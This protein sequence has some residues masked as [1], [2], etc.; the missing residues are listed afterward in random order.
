MADPTKELNI[1]PAPE[2]PQIRL[3]YRFGSENPKDPTEYQI[4]DN[5]VDYFPLRKPVSPPPL[6]AGFFEGL[7]KI[8]EA[9][10]E[11]DRAHIAYLDALIAYQKSFYDALIAWGQYRIAKA[12]TEAV[13]E[14]RLKLKAAITG[15]QPQTSGATTP[16]PS[17]SDPDARRD[18]LAG[19]DLSKLPAGFGKRRA[20]GAGGAAKRPKTPT[21]GT[22]TE[23]TPPEVVQAPEVKDPTPSTTP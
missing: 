6:P 15:S 22:P 16:D 9:R 19:V 21:E 13:R 11:S 5:L 3:D 10:K 2:I 14:R 23:G 4:G 18:R 8:L 17:R 7:D 12:H 20:S 1:P